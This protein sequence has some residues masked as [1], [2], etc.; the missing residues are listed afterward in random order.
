[1]ERPNSILLRGKEFLRMACIVS[2]KGRFARNGLTN[3]LVPPISPVLGEDHENMRC[4]REVLASSRKGA[5]PNA[6]GL[7]FLLCWG[8]GRRGEAEPRYYMCCQLSGIENRW[9]KAYVL[10]IVLRDNTCI[11]RVETRTLVCVLLIQ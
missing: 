7:T 4:W 5:L 10:Y 9:Y 1:M 6:L 3:V 11:E 2:G 8:G